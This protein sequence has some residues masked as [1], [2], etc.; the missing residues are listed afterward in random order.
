MHQILGSLREVP[1]DVAA[2]SR[3]VVE[4]AQ[5]DRAQPL[6]A[7][8][9]HL[10]RSMVEI[11]MPQR[12]DVRGFV[13]ADLARLSPS[14]GVGFAGAL[15]QRNPGLFHQAVGLHVALDRG[16]RAELPERRIGSSPRRRGCRSATGSSSAGDPDTEDGVARRWRRPERSCRGL[17]AWRGAGRRQDRRAGCATCNTI[18]RWCWL[19]HGYRVGSRDATRSSRQEQRIAVLS[20]PRRGRAQ[21]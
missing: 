17:C 21:E 10:E 12:P 7:G 5:R 20:D 1:L 3:V 9:K 15:V 4:D 19:R 2:Q 13:A 8:S 11:E 16:I 18:V 6:A 14:F